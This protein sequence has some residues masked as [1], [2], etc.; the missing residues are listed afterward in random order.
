[1]QRKAYIFFFQVK[2]VV[3]GFIHKLRATCDC[4]KVRVCSSTLGK[5]E[6]NLRK[7]GYQ[8]VLKTEYFFV[9]KQTPVRA[10]TSSSIGYLSSMM[11][12]VRA[13]RITIL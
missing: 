6:I 7:D 1:M 9:V 10:M 8:A 11:R 5:P 2:E 3:D 4:H 12:L 13:R